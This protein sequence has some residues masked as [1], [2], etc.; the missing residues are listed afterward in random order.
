MLVLSRKRHEDILVG[1]GIKIRV[2]AISGTRVRLGIACP[3]GI[4]ILRGEV[5]LKAGLHTDTNRQSTTE[6]VAPRAVAAI[7]RHR[8]R[9]PRSL[10]TP[11]ARF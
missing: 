11:S 7:G 1:E 2:L 3:K 8:P 5:E 10:L 6:S 4:L 9:R